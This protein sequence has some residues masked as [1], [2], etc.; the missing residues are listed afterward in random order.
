MSSEPR[1]LIAGLGLIGG[2]IGM[3]LRAR[4]WR[5]RYIDPNVEESDAQRAGAADARSHTL[6]SADIV[7]I[8]A[9]VDAAIDMMRRMPAIAST[10]VCSVMAALHEIAAERKLPFIA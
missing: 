1:A 7:V 2:S 4:G 9:P 6:E 5:V 3:A 8:A 10:S